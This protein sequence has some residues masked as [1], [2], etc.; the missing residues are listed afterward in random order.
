M[1]QIKPIIF[2]KFEMLIKLSM[3]F[4]VLKFSK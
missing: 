4:E 1:I 2:H 3:F